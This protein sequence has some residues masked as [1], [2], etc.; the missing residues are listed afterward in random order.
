MDSRF[1]GNDD[2]C[3]ADV[4]IENQEALSDI[5]A[6]ASLADLEAMR[7]QRDVFVQLGVEFQPIRHYAGLWSVAP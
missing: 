6:A 1:R 4:T 3:G 2:V 5:A 7:V